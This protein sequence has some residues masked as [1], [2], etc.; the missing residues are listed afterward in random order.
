MTIDPHVTRSV[1]QDALDEARAAATRGEVPVGAVVVDR[2]GRVVSRAGNRVEA[3]RDAS[4][5]AE[6]LAL[7]AAGQALGS[8]HLVGCTLIATLEPCAMC[9]A[10][11]SHFRIDRVLFGAYDPKGGAIE[12]GPRLYDRAGC[13]HR[14]QAVGGIAEGECASLLRAFFKARRE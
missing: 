14:P 6:L 9:A 4:A 8:R 12:H 11:A 2:A 1:M 13:L 5:H 7:R 10:A 3:L